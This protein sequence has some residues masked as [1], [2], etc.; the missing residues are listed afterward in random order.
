M[1]LGVPL[2]RDGE[3]MLDAFLPA[4]RQ[5]GWPLWGHRMPVEAVVSPEQCFSPSCG[6]THPW[7]IGEMLDKLEGTH[8]L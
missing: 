7:R 3:R 5:V 1:L 8:I 2:N 6:C 4:G